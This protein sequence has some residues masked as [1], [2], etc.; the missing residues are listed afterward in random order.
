L[1][2]HRSRGISNN[3]SVNVPVLNADID[4]AE[5]TGLASLWF[6]SELTVRERIQSL[7]VFAVIIKTRHFAGI[8]AKQF[9]KRCTNRFLKCEHR[10]VKSVV[11][12]DD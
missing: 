8:S 10:F 5:K 4:Q 11:F 12:M 6:R 7:N 9:R 2:L 1:S 3:L